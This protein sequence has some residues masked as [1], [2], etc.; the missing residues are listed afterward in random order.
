MGVVYESNLI[1]AGNVS[2]DLD[3][4]T[5]L[6]PVLNIQ[7][8]LDPEGVFRPSPSTG[9]DNSNSTPSPPG[10]LLLNPGESFV[11][12]WVNVEGYEA[13]SI[14]ARSDQISA[15]NGIYTQFAD[16]A[17]GTNTR[18]ARRETYTIDSAGNLAYYTWHGTLGRFMRVVWINGPVMQTDFFISTELHVNATELPQSPVNSSL[19]GGTPAIVTRSVIAGRKDDG[20]NSFDNVNIHQEQG[21]QSLAV[22][23]GHRISQMFGRQHFEY[24]N[25]F[26]ELVGDTLLYTVPASTILHVTSIS[27]S[28][29]NT[30]N[31]NPGKII[32]ADAVAPDTGDTIFSTFVNE[33]SGG[34]QTS[35]NIT[36]SYPEP[37]RVENGLYFN[38]IQGTT[39]TNVNIVG[40]LE[41]V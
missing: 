3:T 40:Y 23:Q 4:E 18:T 27:V 26:T 15:V 35:A 33:V 8:G 12:D 16:D 9:I 34:T 24:N 41:A 11:G 37:L 25:G 36:Q 20:S 22:G 38:E 14:S 2:L 6:L 17:L 19:G 28:I 1:L 13:V 21:F 30:S 10:T 5:P 32:I 7:A 29:A 39:F 31:N